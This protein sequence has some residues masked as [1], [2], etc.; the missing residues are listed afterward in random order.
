MIE[1]QCH[2]GRLGVVFEQLILLFRV[3]YTRTEYKNHQLAFRMRNY[4]HNSKDK[5]LIFVVS[6]QQFNST[7][8]NG[9]DPLAVSNCTPSMAAFCKFSGNSQ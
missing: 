1:I 9:D 6:I 3:L 8:Q 7:F 2:L 5:V 4:M